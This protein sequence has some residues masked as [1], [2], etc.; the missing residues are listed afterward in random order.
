MA[1][2]SVSF[3]SPEQSSL[4]LQLKTKT[5][6]EIDTL[7][8]EFIE[9]NQ[10][11]SFRE[12]LC[13]VQESINS[14][15]YPERT[16]VGS[17][18]SYFVKILLKPGP[19]SIAI[20]KPSDEEPYAEMNPRWIKW[21]HRTLC[22]C[23][24]GR[25]CL[26][27]NGG[28]VSEVMAS[29][30]DRF[31]ALYMVPRTELVSLLSPT[32]SY[33]LSS[34]EEHWREHPKKGS[35]QVFVKGFE[36]AGQLI[37]AL[38]M[39]SGVNV[40]FPRAFQAELEKLICLDWIIRNTDRTIDNWLVKVLWVDIH[41]QEVRSECLIPPINVMHETYPI[42]KLAAIDNGLSF[43]WQHPVDCRSY[44]YSWATLPQCR[45]PFSQGLR[46]HMLRLLNDP[47]TWS[48]LTNRLMA[49]QP[50]QA[51]SYY[52]HRQLAVIRGQMFTLRNCLTL[53]HSTPA[54][55]LEMPLLR[56]EL[57]K[58]YFSKQYGGRKDKGGFVEDWSLGRRVWVRGVEGRGSC[59]FW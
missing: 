27:P 51:S 3:K 2:F 14:A 21:L 20:F 23:L 31:F 36:E 44:P 52:L 25:K 8:Y 5:W 34:P 40:H 24:F 13:S 48:E 57:D 39:L 26:A 9:L 41:S 10:E 50:F 33:P 17:S 6:S 29:V 49:V 12:L 58:E 38:D 46:D 22:P 35:F 18:G 7:R 47:A 59:F 15:V 1:T 53:K 55:L 42:V 54:D 56:V 45:I 16:S 43:P 32:F 4:G 28:A 11:E 30:V 19:S 37:P